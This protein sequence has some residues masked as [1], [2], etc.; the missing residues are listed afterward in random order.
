[1][2]RTIATAAT[3]ASVALALQLGLPSDASAQ[4]APTAVD[5]ELQLLVDVSGSVDSN[6]F[7][8]QR[9]G[10]VQ[11]FQSQAIKDA[12]TAPTDTNG[13]SREGQIAAQLIYWSG[14]TQQ[15]VAVNWTLIDSDTAADNFATAISNASRPFSGQT[16]P[17]SAIAFGDPLF[18]NNGFNGDSLVMDVSG[19]GTRNS[20]TDTSTERDNAL[21]G[22]IDR[23]NGLAIGGNQSVETFYQNEVVGGTDSFFVA[24]NSFTDFQDAIDDK[25][26]AE[27]SGRTPGEVPLPSTVLLLGASLMG[28]GFFSRRKTTA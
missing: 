27:V 16:A 2:L 23:I 1:M 3:T 11:A 4:T 6:E 12:I 7:A 5:V 26:V 19:D 15:N 17:G 25:I 13:N 18:D 28:L 22:G 20:G 8:L 24:A 9:E 14:S 21:A 10:Y